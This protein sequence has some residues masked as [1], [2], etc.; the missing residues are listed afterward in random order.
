MPTSKIRSKDH[1]RQTERA[2]R[3]DLIARLDVAV[4]LAEQLHQQC[5]DTF[6]T[7]AVRLPDMS[8]LSLDERIALGEESCRGLLGVAM[9]L[10]PERTLDALDLR[11]PVDTDSLEA[12]S[13]LINQLRSGPTST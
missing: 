10:A 9:A 1:D 4:L 5:I 12:T 8:E 6:G 2:R 3:A 13:K 7:P 11:L